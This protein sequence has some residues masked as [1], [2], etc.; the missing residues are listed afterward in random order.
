M[1]DELSVVLETFCCTFVNNRIRKKFISFYAKRIV[2]PA[3]FRSAVFLAG[4]GNLTI[5]N[6]EG[7]INPVCFS[8]DIIMSHARFLFKA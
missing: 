4:S 1:D 3:A 7:A 5:A 8:E 6:G 2:I